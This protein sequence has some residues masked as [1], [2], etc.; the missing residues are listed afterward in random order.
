MAKKNR[1]AQRDSFDFR[2]LIYRP[3]LVELPDELYPEWKYLHVL[4]QGTEGACTGFGLAAVVNYLL[5]NKRKAPPSKSE[6][7]ASARM[8]FQMAKRYDQWL[9][10]KYE[11]SSAR[12][13]MKGWFKHGVCRESEWSNMPVLGTVNY[14]TRDRQLAALSCPLGAY[15]RVLPKRTDVH[16]AL[17]ETGIVYAAADTHDGWDK[18]EGKGEIPYKREKGAGGGGHA[19]AIVGYTPEGFLVQNSWGSDWG[20]YRIPKSRKVCEGVALWRYEDFDR[21]VWDIWVAR[22]ALPY[23]SLEALRGQRYTHGGSGT[24]VQEASPPAHEVWGHYVHIDDAQFDPEGEYPTNHEEIVDIVDRLVNGD[25]VEDVRQARPKSLLLFAHG[26][27]N[28]VESSATRVAKWRPVFKSNNVAELHFIWE[29]G[30][31]A[32]LKDVLLGKDEFV[33]QRVSGGSEWW[34]DWV[35]KASR[36]L[37]Y[38]LWREMRDDAESAFATS[39][40][41]GSLFIDELVKALNAAG[42]KAP[43]VHLACHSAGAIWMSHLMERWDSLSGPVIDQLILFAPACTVDLF[44]EKVAPRMSGAKRLLKSASLFRLDDGRERDDSV[45]AVYRKSLLYLVSRSFQEKGAVVPILGMEK[46]RELIEKRIKDAGIQS[47]LKIYDPVSHPAWTK[48]DSHG[49]FDNDLATMNS[50]LKLIL[51]A[52]PGE[53]GFKAEH[54]KGY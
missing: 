3:A 53:K 5:A 10:E 54:M 43:A 7:R 31:L 24:R 40:V 50:L 30:L 25:V 18:A 22:M 17:V 16:A 37:G 15:Y 44:F 35:E 41:A 21:N 52:D 11:W 48:A 19:F 12:G 6:A 36:P 26:G 47:R 32:E 45:A 14:L 13:A 4:D 1:D 28:S 23:E 9:G 29:T 46:C 49:S 20:G 8:L 38:P 39:S 51:G 2:D 42:D 33:R 34:D 27:L